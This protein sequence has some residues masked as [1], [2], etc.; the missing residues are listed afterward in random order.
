MLVSGSLAP[1]FG[2]EGTVTN[3]FIE[4]LVRWAPNAVMADARRWLEQ[5]GFTVSVTS[6]GATL[7][8]TRTQIEQTFS[9]SLENLEPPINL[10]VPTAIVKDVQSVII[11]KPRSYHD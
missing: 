11:P 2:P 9:V 7:L 3:D 5:R 1:A 4:L 10:P 6:S 8:G